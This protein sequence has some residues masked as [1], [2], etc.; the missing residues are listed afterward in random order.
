MNRFLQPVRETTLNTSIDKEL[1][2]MPFYEHLCLYLSS[3]VKWADVAHVRDNAINTLSR[4]QHQLV[5]LTDHELRALKEQFGDQLEAV[6]FVVKK[7]ARSSD[8]DS[9]TDDGNDEQEMQC[10]SRVVVSTDHTASTTT[11]TTKAHNRQPL[12]PKHTW[13]G[14]SKEQIQACL[15]LTDQYHKGQV[16]LSLRND[17]WLIST[18]NGTHDTHE[19]TNDNDEDPGNNEDP[20]QDGDEADSAPRRSNGPSSW[21]T[22]ATSS[23]PPQS[24]AN[25]TTGGYKHSRTVHL[26]KPFTITNS[27]KQKATINKAVSSEASK[28]FSDADTS[29]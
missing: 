8:D 15:R 21:A 1:D 6:M 18:N 24:S 23:K 13:C 27:N 7:G 22:E 11:T 4:L 16:D 20:T 14:P 2:E 25:K 9:D 19:L 29:K 3:L 12:P 5:T 10:D 28:V 17:N 26:M